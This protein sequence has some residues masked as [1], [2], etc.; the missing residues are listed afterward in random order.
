[1]WP[2]TNKQRS[3][4][5]Q[6]VEAAREERDQAFDDLHEAT[7]EADRVYDRIIA[8]YEAEEERLKK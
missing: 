7:E 6:D 8:D 1:M 4:D 3:K 5:A 2:F